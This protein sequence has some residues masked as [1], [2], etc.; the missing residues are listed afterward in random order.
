[1]KY[2]ERF[3]KLK[4]I[5]LNIIFFKKFLFKYNQQSEPYAKISVTNS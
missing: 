1:M 3:G 2:K 4:W 5:A